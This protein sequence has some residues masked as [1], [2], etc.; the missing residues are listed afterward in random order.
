MGK[1]AVLQLLQSVGS[2][3]EYDRGWILVEYGGLRASIPSFA[4]DCLCPEFIQD[5]TRR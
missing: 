1:K 4:P 5:V 2:E 3:Y